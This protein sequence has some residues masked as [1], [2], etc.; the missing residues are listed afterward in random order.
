MN[1]TQQSLPSK[2]LPVESAKLDILPLEDVAKG[3]EKE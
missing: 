1:S 2:S 3:D